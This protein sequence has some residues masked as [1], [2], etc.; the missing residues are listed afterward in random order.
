M[1]DKNKNTALCTELKGKRINKT[2]LKKI[3]FVLSDELIDPEI[4]YTTFKHREIEV[5]IETDQW[6]CE[7]NIGMETLKIEGV[8]SFDDIQNLKKLI[9][10]Q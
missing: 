4:G 10:A 2:N 8:K 1:E 7:I 3:G 5:T 6:I 9:Y